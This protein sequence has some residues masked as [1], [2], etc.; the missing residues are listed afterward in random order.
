[1]ANIVDKSLFGS[2]VVRELDRT[3][4]MRGYPCEI[5][6]VNELSSNANAKGRA[7]PGGR[8]MTCAKTVITIARTRA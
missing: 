2:R 8:S 4:E 1:M 3:T 5:V 6:S 7:T